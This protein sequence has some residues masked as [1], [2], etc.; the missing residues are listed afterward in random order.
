VW[1]AM[2]AGDKPMNVRRRRPG[3]SVYA[4]LVLPQQSWSFAPAAGG[5]EDPDQARVW[6]GFDVQGF[7]E[8]VGG[9]SRF[10]AKTG[11]GSGPIFGYY[12]N[13]SLTIDKYL[14]PI[15]AGDFQKWAF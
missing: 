2:P 1:S 7:D 5:G 9:S 12:N 13:N 11:L 14:C 15:S 3:S 4:C 6:G 10:R 8:H